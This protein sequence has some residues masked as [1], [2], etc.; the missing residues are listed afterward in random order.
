[1]TTAQQFCFCCFYCQITISVVFLIKT[2]PK[3]LLSVSHGLYTNFTDNTQGYR[4]K[5]HKCL[6]EVRKNENGEFLFPH[7]N[8]LF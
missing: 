1:M 8:L 7:I 2:A 5:L 3:S 4:Q 6:Y